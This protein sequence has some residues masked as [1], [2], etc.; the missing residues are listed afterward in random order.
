MTEQSDKLIVDVLT[1]D[2]VQCAACTYMY[3]AIESLPENIRQYIEFKEWSIKNQE[4]IN[5]F[6]E[7]EGKV[8]PSI[9]IGGDLVFESII[10]AY[11]ELLEA[12]SERASGQLKEELEKELKK[13]REEA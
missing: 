3:E 9:V 7:C 8:L 1:L 12:L 4:G 5:K 13:S 10:P 2:R 6:V 11:E